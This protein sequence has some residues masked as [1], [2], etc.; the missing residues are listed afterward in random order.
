MKARLL[1]AVVLPPLLLAADWPQWRG[2]NRDGVSKETG[3][4]AEWTKDLGGQVNPV[5]GGPEIFGWGYTWSPLLDSDKLI[6]VPGG[7]EGTVAA[8]DKQSG[9]VLWRSMELTE[10]CSY[11]SPIFAEVGGIRHYVI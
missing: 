4:L 9:K 6:C 7:P 11:A 5:G 1:V 2:P 10:Q 8:L 3:L